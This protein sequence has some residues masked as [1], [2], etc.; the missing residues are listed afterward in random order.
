MAE[1][2]IER[3][4]RDAEGLLIFPPRDYGSVDARGNGWYGMT[5]LILTEACLFA[6][7]LF[8]YYYMALHYGRAWPP[9]ELPGF[10][11]SGPNTVI[12]IISSVAVWA[13][14]EAIKR[15]SRW[16]CFTGLA[17][18]FVLGCIFVGV[19]LLEWRNKPFAID[20]S[21][22]GSL[23]FTV[24]GFHMAHVAGGLLMIAPL[25]LWTA[26]GKFDSRRRDAVSNGALYWHFVD[27]VWLTVFF[28]FYIT[29]YMFH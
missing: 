5:L 26:L 24:T 3:E 11:L 25:M 15:N 20:T 29:P 4:T 8:S 27:A 9:A 13:G 12:L 19:Q 2:A 7:L 16:G 23:Y 10:R 17:V 21:S 18:G 22:Y 14:E 1:A 6:F 28:T